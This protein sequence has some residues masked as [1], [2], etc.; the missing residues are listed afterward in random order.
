MDAPGDNVLTEFPTALDAVECAIEMQRVLQ[1]R[2]AGLPR[3]R[4]ME[5]RV[6]VHLGDAAYVDAT[7]LAFGPGET[8][9]LHSG[10]ALP[11]DID[12][13]G[14]T[15]WVSHHRIGE[16]VGAAGGTELCPSGEALDGI[17][18]E[19]CDAI[20]TVP[21]VGEHWRVSVNR[22]RQRSNSSPSASITA[23]SFCADSRS[24]EPS[25]WLLVAA[26]LGCLAVLWRVRGGG[27]P[28]FRRRCTS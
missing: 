1:A 20:V 17:P 7:T 8:G 22:Q 13:D 19:G 3:E 14:Y 11:E 10:G 5:L 18:S 23:A 26:G 12:D 16:V 6:V 28:C 25:R 4:R 15:G 9:P 24:P 21:Y 2:N 27:S